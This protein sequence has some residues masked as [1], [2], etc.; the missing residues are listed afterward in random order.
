MIPSVIVAAL[1]SSSL[2]VDGANDG[3]Q[4]LLVQAAMRHGHRSPTETFPNDPYQESFW[5]QGFGEMTAAGLGQIFELGR[6]V[7]KRYVQQIP[8]I[9]QRYNRSE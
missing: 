7:R 2:Q 1:L 6:F 5:P 9:S 4:L 3:D 8:L